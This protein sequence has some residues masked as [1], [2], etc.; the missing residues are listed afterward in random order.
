MGAAAFKTSGVA[1]AMLTYTQDLRNNTQDTTAGQGARATLIR[2]LML[3][4]ES[5]AQARSVVKLLTAQID[6]LHGKQIEIGVHTTYTST[7]S[8]SAVTGA[9]PGGVHI[10][11]SSGQG[12][13]NAAMG[14]AVIVHVHGSV[15]SG[16]EIGRVV[17]TYINQKTLRNGSTQT[18]IP[19]RKH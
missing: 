15:L 4:G 19:G 16:Q 5:A 8:P 10:T 13:M 2:D 11:G 1:A 12:P 6:G 18:F 9:S 14:A 3:A 17:Q 7:G